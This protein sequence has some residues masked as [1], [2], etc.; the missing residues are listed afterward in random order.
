MLVRRVAIVLVAILTA[1]L[2]A[3]LSSVI[4]AGADSA[5]NID[6]GD[7]TMARSTTAVTDFVFPI[8]LEYASSNTVTVY[9]YTQ[10]GT[11]R[12]TRDYTSEEGTVSFAPGTLSKTVTVPV[13]PTT[14]HT[15]NLYFYLQLSSPTNA[16]VNHGTGTGTIIDP[17]LNPYINVGDA[18]VT[19]G[20]GAAAVATFTATVS[21]ASV[22]PI[23]FQYTTS[24]GTAVAGTD[25]TY[26][27]GTATVAPGQVTAQITVPVTA[28]SQY[29]SSRY[30]YLNLADPTDA[31][32]G[33]NQGVG[34]ILYDNHA[35]WITV[36]DNAVTAGTT[37]A[38]TLDFDVRLTSA[39][40]FPVTVDY[41]TSDGSATAAANRY[42]PAFGTLTFAP[43]VTS[44]E[45]PVSI[46]TETSG[47][48]TSYFD[49]SLSN[50]SSGA[51][52][53]RST[54]YGT[55]VGPGVAYNQLMVG[56]TGLVRPTSGTGAM[57]FTVT[58]E[59][60]ATSTVTVNYATQNNS[61]VAP[62]DYTSASGTLTFTAG[63]TSKVVTVNVVGNTT[64]FADVDFYLD[65][66]AASGATIDRTSAFGM[67]SQ[68]NVA[69]VLSVDSLA[70]LK[71]A[72]GTATADFTIQLSSASPNPV[73]VVA[74]TSDG[75]A[76]VASGA[77]TSESST[78]TIAAGQTSV[79]VPV[80]VNGNT[81]AGPDLYF[82]L[83]ISSPTDA[84]LAGNNSAYGYIVNPN[85]NPTVSI[86]DVSVYTPVTG[87][88]AASFTVKLSGASTQMVTVAYATSNGSAVAGVDYAATNGTLTFAPGVTSH[89][90]SV[91][92]DSTTLAHASRNFYVSL[93]SPTNTTIVSS[94]GTGTLID[95]EVEPYL[96]V[97]N[98]TVDDGATS[99][100]VTFTV[101]LTSA[102]PNPV[103]VSYATSNGSAVAGTQY[104][105]VSGSLTFAAGVTV[106]TVPVTVL[107]DTVKAADTYF[108][109]SL[110]SPTNALLSN[111]SSGQAMI[112]NTAVLPGLSVGDVTIARPTTGSANA[113]FTITLA[114]ASPNTVTVDYATANG[115]AVASTDFTSTSGTA[116]FT[117]GQTTQQVTVPILADSAHTSDLYYYL[118]LSSPVHGQLLR[119]Y[120]IGYLVDQVSPVTGQSYVTV[121][122]AAVSTPSSGTTNAVFTV[123]LGDASASP[124]YVRY[125]TSN[126]SAVSGVDYTEVRGTLAF[127]AGQTS[128]TVD[129]PVNASTVASTDKLFYFSISVAS[130]P[131]TVERSSAYGLI[132]NP[133]PNSYA[134]VAGDVAVIK[135]DSGT[136]DAVFTVQLS[137][138]QTQTESV[139]YYTQ[140]GSATQPDFYLQ[141]VGT[142]V[143]APGQTSLTVSVPVESNTYIEPTTYFYLSIY[144]PVGT[145][146]GVA[147]GV[148]Y[149]LDPDVF[150]ISGTVL[151]PSGGGAAGVTVTRTG[152]DQPAVSV[153][154]A[155][156]GSFS[157]PNTLDGQYILTPNLTGDSFLPGTVAVTVRGANA[158]VGPFL[159]YSGPAI[160]GQAATGTGVADSGVTVT[161]TGGGQPTTVEATDGLGYYAFGSLPA[162]TGY[163]VTATKT[164]STAVPA[165][166]TNTVST[167]N[168]GGQNFV[169]VTGTHISGQVSKGGVGVAGVTMTLSGG[170]T[171]TTTVK[172]N[173]QGYYGFSGLASVSGGTSYTVTPTLTGQ[174]FTPSALSET[175]TPTTSAP[176]TNFTEN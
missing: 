156:N 167:S 4:P 147:S 89:T 52:L 53:L 170:I 10:N 6:V 50:P 116:T 155:A 45:V 104:S 106:Q 56:D 12:S 51:S 5:A 157:F 87:T 83:T 57:T 133:D 19:E 42:V 141:T 122:D 74:Q 38:G 62:G 17:T 39:A 33:E 137:G 59:P 65:L 26:E 69:P 115:T 77:Y 54:G 61:A 23:T 93:S 121:S 67:I 43:G 136:A 127:A 55:I 166:Y 100:T 70:V 145:T 118:D 105:S 34:T 129:V 103:T 160:T 15:G 114:P 7:V 108:Y 49:L 22:N 151:D 94:T 135:G 37:T 168:I 98:P 132:V 90:V 153:T 146:V 126:S 113:V 31:I 2:G 173:S 139:D 175:V 125:S 164:G 143:F 144:Q 131:A 138:P 66:S 28:T 3:G 16:V 14:L 169:M 161:L 165:S 142:L 149:I 112:L 73:T 134:S 85:H 58:L 176:G 40:T 119:S 47:T 32:I 96:T 117:P 79:T 75:S 152:N 64:S 25:Y 172:T 86:N 123:S 71:P 162:G 148:A 8:T 48:A 60:A 1:V 107:P 159:A 150:T 21:T 102:T 68:G 95:D 41:G 11:A 35:A 27:H 78:F 154:S 13:L 124:I 76:T 174:T 20:T 110:S 128:K 63:Q 91:T 92:V 158:A 171:P 101:S 99:S 81:S 46:G 44:I 97:N 80:T 18:T 24:N 30:F 72:S 130:G 29:S 111:A 109:L 88:V 140:D 9:Y 36:D 120:G 82:Y 84:V 163:V